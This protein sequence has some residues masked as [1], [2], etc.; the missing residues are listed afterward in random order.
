M[1]EPTENQRRIRE[2]LEEGVP[3]ARIPARLGIS[4]KTVYEYIRKSRLPRNSIPKEQGP[5]EQKILAA[6]GSGMSVEEVGE[7][8][9]LAPVL[10]SFIAERANQ[11]MRGAG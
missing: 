1:S 4:G 6:L 3:A 11:R 8:F 7:L 2:L 10:V 9:S 5:R